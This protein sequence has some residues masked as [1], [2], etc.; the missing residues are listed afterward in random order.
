M[1]MAR[2]LLMIAA[3]LGGFSACLSAEPVPE[4]E[5]SRFDSIAA[6]LD[7]QV[8]NY[9]A[10]QYCDVYKNFMQDFFGPGHILA[11]TVAAG[12]YLRHELAETEKFEGPLYEKTGFN[13]NFYRVNISLIKDNVIPYELYFANFVESVQNI[14]P[15]SGEEWMRIWN[16][17]DGVIKKKNMHF[18]DEDSDRMR[19]SG[20]F[21]DGNYVVH[22][23]KR[24]DDS[25]NFHY[26]IISRE[27]FEKN[28]LPLI[29]AAK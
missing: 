12:R 25:V 23:S 1:Y 9:P 20:Q 7:Y 19:L 15:P 22:H 18:A 2:L 26:R 13:G 27:N 11:D 4:N 8:S 29:E 14:V 28:L 5:T 17:I 16:E 21:E 24:Y 6:A 3:L 10:S